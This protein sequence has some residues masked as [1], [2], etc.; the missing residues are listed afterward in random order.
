MDTKF[1]KQTSYGGITFRYS[2]GSSLMSGR[3]LHPYHEILY[4]LDG[5]AEFLSG[6]IR[7][8]AEPG[9][10]F[11][12][13][14]EHFHKFV[15]GDSE[16]YTRLTL[17]ISDIGSEEELLSNFSSIM[18]IKPPSSILRIAE[19]M[20]RRMKDSLHHPAT[21]SFMY[22]ATLMLLSELSEVEKGEPAPSPSHLAECVRFIEEHFTREL[23]TQMIAE[24]MHM[25]KSAVYRLFIEGLGTSPHQYIIDRRLVY[26]NRLINDGTR[27]SVAAQECGYSDYS[28][29]YRAY[30]KK[31]GISPTLQKGKK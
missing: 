27:A 31:F 14:K 29:F 18:V 2:K 15:I 24:S 23:T 12:I 19:D 30:I 20:H 5:D 25:S 8:R 17:S 7:T 3:E 4:Y 6:D 9:T 26:A 13:P 11:V 10:L 1:V 28:S 21:P 16:K 22:G